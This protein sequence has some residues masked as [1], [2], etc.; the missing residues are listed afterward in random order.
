MSPDSKSQLFSQSQKLIIPQIETKGNLDTPDLQRSAKGAIDSESELGK[1]IN[2]DEIELVEESLETGNSQ[3]I[4]KHLAELQ[5]YIKDTISTLDNISTEFQEF[6]YGKVKDSLGD[7]L[8]IKGYED[9]IKVSNTNGLDFKAVAE[10]IHANKDKT[11]EMVGQI[12]EYDFL[13]KLDLVFGEYLGELENLNQDLEQR[14]NPYQME[15]SDES[16]N[17]DSEPESKPTDVVK[18]I[19]K[20]KQLKTEFEVAR[21]KLSKMFEDIGALDTESA[22]VEMIDAMMD[23]FKSGG[24]DSSK[25]FDLCKEIDPE[26]VGR[27]LGERDEE[28]LEVLTESLEGKVTEFSNKIVFIGNIAPGTSALILGKISA[29]LDSRIDRW[30]DNAG[31][32]SICIVLKSLNSTDTDYTYSL[33]QTKKS[34]LIKMLI[35]QTKP[36]RSRKL[37]EVFAK[38]DPDFESS[39]LVDNRDEIKKTIIEKFINPKSLKDYFSQI[40][41]ID[42]NFIGLIINENEG[43]FQNAFLRN[44]NSS[45][46]SLVVLSGVCPEFV[47]NFLINN[48]EAILES[49]FESNRFS[50]SNSNTI[51][52]LNNFNPDYISLLFEE[53]KEII[54]RKIIDGLSDFYILNNIYDVLP[55]FTI[56]LFEDNKDSVTNGL[57][58]DITT[59]KA[60]IYNIEKIAPG[61]IANF[62]GENKELLSGQLKTD[63]KNNFNRFYD[64][65]WIYLELDKNFSKFV[66]EFL[67]ENKAYIK[68]C[69]LDE[70]NDDPRSFIT[71]IP[72]F[73]KIQ[74][75]FPDFNSEFLNEN[76]DLLSV[77]LLNTLSSEP[78]RFIETVKFFNDTQPNL[79]EDVVQNNKPALN[80][81]LIES[82]KTGEGRQSIQ[83]YNLIRSYLSESD[84]NDELKEY[85]I[86]LELFKVKIPGLLAINNQVAAI[87]AQSENPKDALNRIISIFELESVPDFVK[88][89]FVFKYLYNPQKLN[90]L[91]IDSPT[92]TNAKSETGNRIYGIC[93]RDLAK[94][95][96]NSGEESLMAFAKQI[97]EIENIDF[98]TIGKDEDE[99]VQNEKLDNIVTQVFTLQLQALKG[100]R[101]EKSNP[102]F[103]INDFK[104]LKTSEKVV[105]LKKIIGNH[106]SGLIGELEKTYLTPLGIS[107]FSDIEKQYSSKLS[108]ANNRNIENSNNGIE[109]GE[110]LIKAVNSH[111]F[112]SILN[113]GLIAR[114]FLGDI[115]AD[116]DATPLDT[117]FLK[118]DPESIDIDRDKIKTYGNL[119]C[120]IKDRGQFLDTS[121]ENLDIGDKSYERWKDKNEV[122]LSG[123]VDSKHFGVRTGIDSLELDSLIFNSGDFDSLISNYGDNDQF[124][125]L[126]YHLARKN[127][128]VPIY[129]KEKKLIFSQK[130]WEES[131][132]MFAGTRFSNQNIEVK[133]RD[134]DLSPKASTELEKIK[135]DRSK[136]ENQDSIK[137]L[138]D[139]ILNRIHEV[140]Q[141]Y[142]IRIRND[143]NLDIYGAEIIDTG[144]TGRGTNKADGIDFDLAVVI[145]LQNFEENK[146]KLFLDLKDAFSEI[147]ENGRVEQNGDTLRLFSAKIGEEAIDVDISIMPKLVSSGIVSSDMVV[148]EKFNNISTNYGEEVCENVKQQIVLAKTM[149][150]EYKCYKKTYSGESEPSG[151][152]GIGVENWILDNNGSFYEACKHLLDLVN[153]NGEPIKLE[154]FKEEYKLFDAG[155]N[156]R[157]LD[158]SFN[159]KH[160]NFISA[161][162]QKGFDNLIQMAKDAV[163]KM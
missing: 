149:M 32:E 127:F 138:S 144:S 18:L 48:E 49:F 80:N 82:I 2:A 41:R 11:K 145:D 43:E 163:D 83:C 39:S 136:Q 85:E 104:N 66:S 118:S 151:I 119:I 42:P 69:I 46:E 33:I 153:S 16:R 62:I 31:I 71:M 114:E 61:F 73:K 55:E 140:L 105:F 88:R 57:L 101:F 155:T 52:T 44:L 34:K 81:S 97:Q 87:C 65:I 30:I 121:S 53:N 141:K 13:N 161:L 20:V 102:E 120:V 93:F 129:D 139:E 96:I 91:E 50:I 130:D 15:G 7:H 67:F 60:K 99:I 3:E 106:D 58:D 29:A 27:F 124:S 132:K 5:T 8:Q 131:K 12:G 107:K 4:E 36:S 23:A 160:N 142:K 74:I 28:I 111:F 148:K 135:Q 112:E 89:L 63:L 14:Q 117:D 75:V 72:F 90:N 76:K 79:M 137:T 116:S 37:S 40:E 21:L 22:D 45:V 113:N 128:Y 152:G 86:Y 92:L 19:N 98:D 150:S 157:F 108:E 147:G 6:G 133:S 156:L 134:E 64:K 25:I 70:I 47:S 126:K 94:I 51:K 38:I 103:Q 162:N 158:G 95:N 17:K 100:K 115:N 159:K 122:F 84:A 110:Y 9:L 78:Q 109:E 68:D 35:A 143:S 59:F 54:A 154:K 146:D 1:I 125:Y 26:I 77:G 123:K 10:Y 56:R 24:L